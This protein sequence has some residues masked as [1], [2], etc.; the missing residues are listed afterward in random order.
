MTEDLEL[1]FKECSTESKLIKYAPSKRFKNREGKP[2]EWTLKTITT[3]ENEELV[4]EC[5]KS[6]KTRA[7]IERYTDTQK[8][9]KLLVA[10]CVVEPNLNREDLQNNWGVTCAEDVPVKMLMAGEYLNL[11]K[12]IN[13]IN[14][15]DSYEE[16][17]EDMGN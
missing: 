15:F 5:E 8:Y 7:G 12:K 2:L 4:K 13:D 10:A 6:V 11:L 1:Y 9:G 17:I 3:A 16:I 14:E